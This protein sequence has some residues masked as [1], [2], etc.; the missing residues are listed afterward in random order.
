M[1]ISNLHKA[2]VFLLSLPKE[3]VALLLARLRPEQVAAVTAEMSGLGEIDGALREAVAREFAASAAHAE[4]RPTA[5]A[6]P[7][8]FLHDLPS[9]DLL[10]LLA[11]EH[12]QTVAL[13]LSFLPSHQAADVLGGLPADAQLSVI[14]RIASMDEPRPEVIR[15]VEEGLLSRLSSAEERPGENRGVASVVRM[16]NAMEPAVER[17]LLGGLAEADPELVRQIRRAMF[18]ADVAGCQE[19]NVAEAG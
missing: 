7:F 2:A 10:R 13:V 11:G 8:E 16:L 15:D 6:S 17:E 1:A 14:C 19:P 12:P 9:D 3:Q 5:E 18:G 4:D